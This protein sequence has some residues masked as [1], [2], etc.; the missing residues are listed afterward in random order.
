MYNRGLEINLGG[1]VVRVGQFKWNMDINA[2]FLKN[3]ITKMPDET[4]TIINGT[5]QLAVGHGL[6]DFW[7]R[8]W[9][10]VDPA[11]G[12]GLYQ[13]NPL[14]PGSA[15]DQRTINGEKFTINPNNARF[16]Y[17]GSAIPKIEG[18][19]TNTFSYGPVTLSV[20]TNYKIGGKIYDSSYAGLM[21]YSN[22]GGSLH[23][24]VLKSWQ[25]P[26]DTSPIPRL[27]VNRST[28]NNALSNR[29]LIDGSYISFR[30]A[31]LAYDLPKRLVN[32]A[33][34]SNVRIFGTGENL[35]MLSKRK[36]MDP[37]ESFNGTV[38]DAYSPTRTVSLGIN[39]SF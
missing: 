6:Y 38:S 19:V 31:T 29:W 16:D 14:V 36:G 1:D 2:A 4:P 23:A 18:S 13:I 30:S 7:M 20:Q 37:T 9:A 8:Q 24:D 15:A 10:G 39:A 34:L 17:S 3:K 12:M 35:L 28:F 32:K 11:D 21:S 22:Y 26:G 5:K 25:A 33:G 27:D